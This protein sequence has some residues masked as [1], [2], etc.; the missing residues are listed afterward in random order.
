MAE[1]E[2]LRVEKETGQ[3]F[4]EFVLKRHGKLMKALSDEVKRALERYMDAEG[5]GGK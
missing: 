1:M 2:I 3:R 4:K 5:C